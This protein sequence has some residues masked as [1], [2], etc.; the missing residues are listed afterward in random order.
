MDP[1]SWGNPERTVNYTLDKVGNRTNV[2]ENGIDTPYTP[3]N[4]NRYTQVGNDGVTTGPEHQIGAYQANSYDYVGDTYL[5]RITQGGNTY[6]LGY[7]ALGRCVIRN[8]NGAITYYV[9]DGDKAILE[10]GAT[11]A[12]NIYGAGI[13]EIVA[14]MESGTTAYYF[15]QDHEGSVTHVFNASGVLVEQYRYDAFG[16]PTIKDGNGTVLPNGTAINNRFLFTGR[17]YA[18]DFGVYEYRNR[19]YHPGLGRFM[20]EDPKGFDAGDY[21][22]FRYCKND[23]EDL[24]DPMG[25]G[26]ENNVKPAPPVPPPSPQTIT[27]TLQRLVTSL[28]SNIP[29]WTNVASVT[30]TV[31]QQSQVQN[32]QNGDPPGKGTTATR[33]PLDKEPTVTRHSTEH[34]N[35][36]NVEQ[37]WKVALAEGKQPVS[38]GVTVNESFNVEDNRCSTTRTEVPHPGRTYPGGFLIDHIGAPFSLSCPT[39]FARIK[40]TL[41]LPN[42][43]NLTW[44]YTV[45]APNSRFPN[46]RITADTYTATFQ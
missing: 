36:I 18:K 17:E 43:A 14:R 11:N 21:N 45:Y 16:A 44:H 2:N 38:A 22:L 20:S 9:Y 19:A 5:A 32:T 24:T 15:A 4:I 33:S 40:Q 23:P 8:L 46:G 13:D 34:G 28:G 39:G 27:I 37:R 3:D 29:R 12:Y 1:A 42:G 30:L 41:W 25:L 35:Y 7:D 26:P 31:A 6:T 10:T